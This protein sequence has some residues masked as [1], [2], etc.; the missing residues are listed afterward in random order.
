[1]KTFRVDLHIHTVLSP[2]GSL[3]MS[4]ETVMHHAKARKIDILG[5]TDHNSTL[6]CKTYQKVGREH[7]IEVLTGVEVNSKEEIHALAFFPDH[8]SLDLF[9]EYLNEHLPSI[10]NKPD[11][12]G[13]QVVI[14]EHEEIVD[15]VDSLLINALDVS[16]D[17]VEKYV[18]QLKGI[19]IPA[20]IDRQVS[21]IVSQ[22]GF[23]PPDLNYDALG[24]S[25][26]SS[27]EKIL[28]HHSYLDGQ[29]FI[30][31]S[32]AHFPEDIGLVYSKFHMM[33]AS[34]ED[35]R[36]ALHGQDGHFCESM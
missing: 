21:S 31:N 26:H 20:H 30:Q 28:K 19:F 2:C 34:F 17:Q 15:Q 3:D 9:Q 12:F 14:D 27:K 16:L 33:E 18:H 32:D 11:L 24:L 5:I 4:P 23:I 36:K 25:K 35:V 7:G 13:Y 6:N 10:K 1:M 8:E 29:T 22:L